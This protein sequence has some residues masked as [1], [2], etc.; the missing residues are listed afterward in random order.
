MT[1]LFLRLLLALQV[2]RLT[3]FLYR[4]KVVVLAYHGFTDQ[5]THPGIENSQGKH[6]HIDTFRA[7][8]AYLKKH[9]NVVPLQQIVDHYVNGTALPPRP[10][11]ITID[12]GYESN[13]TLAYRA[14]AEHGLPATIFL[15]TDFVDQKE[16]QWTDRIEYALST[17]CASTLDV[18]I[19]DRTLSYGLSDRS[20]KLACD[21][22]LRTKLK[23]IPQESRSA[24]VDAIEARLGQ[25]LQI[26]ED[27]A[28]IYRPLVWPQVREMLASGLVS[29]GSH[30]VSHLI[31]TRC[32]PDRARAELVVS[33]HRIEQQTTI[34][35]QLFC[36]P[37]GQPGCF[38]G[39]TKMMLGDA[40]Y[41]CGVTT[42]F[43]MNNGSSDVFELKRLY[44]D[45]PD[46]TR[47]VLT[48][49]GVIGLL[50]E[51]RRMVTAEGSG[52]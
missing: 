40:G 34:S 30:T 31:V 46:M 22:D 12:D 50:D 1:R 24:I 26:G 35:C 51:A 2:P 23:T 25:R 21:R 13:Y 9:Y 4:T 17:T 39:S 44:T 27:I 18:A 8:L 41:A 10:L 6:L 49:S 5:R 47:F 45:R 7:Q 3:R 33:K 36:Y 42:V 16:L 52:R 28:P 29:I 48:V 11:A 37:N 32:H 20:S 15:T 14:L 19:G 43:G 38:D